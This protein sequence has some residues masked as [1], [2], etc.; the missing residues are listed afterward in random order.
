MT[1][2]PWAV[3]PV[4]LLTVRPGYGSGVAF[5][6]DTLRLEL[7]SQGHVQALTDRATAKALLGR[8][9]PICSGMVE[10]K[11]LA[12]KLVKAES[13]RLTF[14]LGKAEAQEEWEEADLHGL[15]PIQRGNRVGTGLV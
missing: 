2:R 7:D 10:G 3:L 12:G 14:A 6:T 4:L 1:A 15:G 11:W 13:G 8:A 9:Y 5:E